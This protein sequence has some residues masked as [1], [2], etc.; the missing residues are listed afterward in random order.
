MKH[1]DITY[2]IE[3]YRSE[4]IIEKVTFRARTAEQ[5]IE[6]FKKF[7]GYRKPRVLKATEIK[8]N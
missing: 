8:L 6:K 2:S 1:Y 5:A 3:V 4:P 7:Y